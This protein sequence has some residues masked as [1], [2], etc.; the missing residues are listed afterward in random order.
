MQ[1]PINIEFVGAQSFQNQIFESIR[2]QIL[3]GQLKPGAPIPSTR[4][5]SEQLG[6]SRNTVVLAYD[7]LVAEDYI[8]TQKNVG[9]FVNANLP[10][11]SLL[12]KDTPL[13]ERKNEERQAARHPVLFRG[14]AQTVVNPNRHKLAID[15]WVGRPDPR[16]FPTKIWRRL[17]LRNL[18]LAGSNLTEY[19]NPVGIL[20]LRQAIAEYLGPARG[21]NTTPEQII[22]VN[23]S[24][25]ALN[26][27]SRLFIKEGT[28]VVTECPYKSDAS[29]LV[30]QRRKQAGPILRPGYL[31]RNSTHVQPALQKKA[32]GEIG[33]VRRGV[34]ECD[35][36][37]GFPRES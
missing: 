9:T 25:E 36:A 20:S 22:V 26:L 3:S 8:F 14:Q 15:F 37:M 27:V 10:D 35:P 34:T 23:G 17:M 28:S 13:A 16:S 24:Q 1:L 21:I 2:R 5:L 7:R 32:A 19:S 4:I 18:S 31:H 11:D 6:V 12:L 30:M 29:N 33:S